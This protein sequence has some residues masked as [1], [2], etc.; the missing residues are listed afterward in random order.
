MCLMAWHMW[1]TR[2]MAGA[3]APMA[4][5]VLAPDVAEATA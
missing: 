2:Q 4:Q 3:G 1:R 5:P